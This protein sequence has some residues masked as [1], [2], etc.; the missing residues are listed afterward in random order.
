MI[1]RR[2]V[3]VGSLI[4]FLPAQKLTFQKLPLPLVIEQ[5]HSCTLLEK[6]AKTPKIPTHAMITLLDEDTDQRSSITYGDALKLAHREKKV[7]KQK[8]V[9][10]CV[11]EFCLVPTEPDD[12]EQEP[13]K[14]TKMKQKAF[15]MKDAIADHELQLKI[16]HMIFSLEKGHNVKV[17]IERTTSKQAVVSARRFTVFVVHLV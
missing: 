14:A 17:Q 15:H 7:L 13:V 3:K 5:F 9:N 4:R 1:S 16:D 2:V 11:P 8:Q 6:D 12:A 10:E